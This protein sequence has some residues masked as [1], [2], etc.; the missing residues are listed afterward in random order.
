L[1]GLGRFGVRASLGADRQARRR[2][3]PARAK[4]WLRRVLGGRRRGRR[5][6]PAP[7]DWALAA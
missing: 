5:S 4:P 2:A 3:H 6:L 1:R 7:M